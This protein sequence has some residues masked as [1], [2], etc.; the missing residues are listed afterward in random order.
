M[1]AA[2]ACGLAAASRRG[3]AEELNPDPVQTKE[4]E[5][6]LANLSREQWQDRVREAKRHALDLAAQVKSHRLNGPRPLFE[7]ERRLASER[8]LN[9]FTLER[10]DMV[11]TDK[12]IF[13]FRGSTH[14]TRKPADFEPLV[15]PPMRR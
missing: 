4:I 2:V 12:G 9:D 1:V 3:R 14:E 8:V 10:G 5:D 11:V 13:V 15:D 7:D 6:P